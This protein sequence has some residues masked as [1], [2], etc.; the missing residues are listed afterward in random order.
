V[1]QVTGLQR[2]TGSH[3]LPKCEK[4]APVEPTTI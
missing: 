2:F 4:F 1:H 3:H